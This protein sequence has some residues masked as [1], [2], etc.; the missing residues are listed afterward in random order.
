MRL[1]VSGKVAVLDRDYA[2][3]DQGEL[4][5]LQGEDFSKDDISRLRQNLAPTTSSWVLFQTLLQR[6]RVRVYGGGWSSGIWSHSRQCR[7][8][9]SC[10]RGCNGSGSCLWYFEAEA[11]ILKVLLMLLHKRK[12]RF[13]SGKILE[14]LFPLRIEV[15]V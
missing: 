2:Q 1:P 4:S 15:C 12:P 5:Q 3:E 14:N 6:N 13:L 8:G 11:N 7:S 10:Y 9:I